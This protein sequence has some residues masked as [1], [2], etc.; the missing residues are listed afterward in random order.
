MTDGDKI[1]E[2]PKCDRDV[3]LYGYVRG[4]YLK[5]N[6]KVHIPGLGDYYM[7]SVT[8]LPDPCPMPGSEKKRRLDERDKLIYAPM[9]DIGDVTY[10]ADAVYVN[11][12]ENNVRF[13]SEDGVEDITG[14]EDGVG[15][16]D[17]AEGERLVKGLHKVKA[18]IDEGLRASG[19]ISLF[20]GGDALDVKPERK[21][22]AA[23]PE[24]MAE[25]EEEEEG[26]M[27]DEEDSDDEEEEM[28]LSKMMGDADEEDSRGARFEITHNT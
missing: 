28:D 1:H 5:P 12:P 14:E 7:R 17:D 25:E 16:G 3:T 15:M 23:F 26:G 24:D 4:T 19:G 2:N 13:T 20:S 9:G 22:R 8:H 11:I 18:T 27:F 10:D 6:G 21:R